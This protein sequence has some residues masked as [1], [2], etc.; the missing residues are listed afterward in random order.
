MTD[1]ITFAIL[2][3]FL[4][5]FVFAIIALILG[6]INLTPPPGGEERE[7]ESNQSPTS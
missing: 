3:L 4:A 6:I 1:I 5:N 7:N 2:L